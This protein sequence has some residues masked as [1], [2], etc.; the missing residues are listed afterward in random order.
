MALNL[1]DFD[2]MRPT[3]LFNQHFGLELSP[4]DLLSP[5]PIP[6]IMRSFSP[7]LGTTGPYFRPWQLQNQDTGSTVKFDKD[8]YEV[9]SIGQLRIIFR[10][11]HRK[12]RV[13]SRKSIYSNS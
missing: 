10:F 8:K 1:F 4:E 11:I 2:M 9:S 6:S 7:Y 5:L 12:S 13:V 3:Q